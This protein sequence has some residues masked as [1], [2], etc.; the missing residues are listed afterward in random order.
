MRSYDIAFMH[1][2]DVTMLVMVA[3]LGIVGAAW[4]STRALEMRELFK[5][6]SASRNFDLI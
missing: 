6:N 2:S 1:G 5:F 3:Y 4:I